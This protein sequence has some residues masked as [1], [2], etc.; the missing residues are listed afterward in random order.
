MDNKIQKEYFIQKAKKI[1]GNRYDYSKV[2]YKGSREKVCIICPEHGEFWQT[3]S[4]HLRAKY[5]CPMCAKNNLKFNTEEFIER[6][7]N[8]HGNKYDYSKANYINN[9]TRLCI[10]C[11]RHGEFWQTPS[12]HL[13]GHGCPKCGEEISPRKTTGTFIEECISLY[14]DKF[15]YDKT[16]YKN[17]MTPV[18]ITCK[19]H[20]D[21]SVTPTAFLRGCG[22]SLCKKQKEFIDEARKRHGDR[23][24]YSK[25]VYM[26][27]NV[28]VIISDKDHGT[29]LQ[30]PYAH[31][32][33][34]GCSV[35]DIKWTYEIC[36]SIAENYKYLYDFC[37]ENKKCYEKCK[38]NGWLSDFTWLKK[39][40]DDNEL[41]RLVYVYEFNNNVA[42][43]GLTN[44]LKRRHNQH[45]GNKSM[46][47]VQEN[48]AVYRYCTDNAI[49]FVEPKILEDKL[50]I[51]EARKKEREWINF[52]KK[53][54][55]YMLNKTNG[56]EIGGCCLKSSKVNDKEFILS[57]AKKYKSMA[58][59]RKKNRTLYNRIYKQ[60]LNAI[61]FPY[62]KRTKPYVYTEQFIKQIVEKYPSK[63]LLRE[64]EARV[65]QYLWEYGLLETYYPK[66][67]KS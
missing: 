25:V 35:V 52:Y 20:G 48:D 66:R 51:N 42:Y 64:K 5:A 45:M 27:S 54:G 61:C 56:G 38:K 49:P 46:F 65:Y 6:A 53:H 9:K 44:D 10:I 37:M 55:W 50:S 13:G 17:R 1:H 15:L 67:I 29:F 32:S 23:Y 16:V 36:K 24:D 43:V 26:G 3:P 60:N 34:T 4:V 14:G 59:I 41:C 31:L 28:P 57:E 33:G 8:I 21:F 11:P 40:V 7:K 62:V 18:I 47:G 22:C 58:E 12:Q 63:K 39:K 30:R 2:E 19:I